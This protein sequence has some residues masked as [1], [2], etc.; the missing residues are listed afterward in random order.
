MKKK[1]EIEKNY[2]FLRDFIFRIKEQFKNSSSSIHKAR[3]EIKILKYND[4]NITAKSFKVPNFFNRLI[5]SFF[6]KSKAKKSYL[7]AV[8]VG[9]FT[10]KPIGYIEFYKNS[11]LNESY[12]LSEYFEYDFTIREPLLNKNFKNKDEIFRAFARF[13]FAL[14]E[15][16]IFHKDFSPGNILVKQKDE[17]YIF[18]IV[19]INRMKFQTLSFNLRAKS[20]SK[21][22]ANDEDLKTVSNEY[23]KIYGVNEE[24]FTKKTLYYSHQL[25]RKMNFKKRLKGERVVD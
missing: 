21:L 9:D 4:L 12:F 2:P 8:K 22:W 20:F 3:N 5:Y 6:R 7:H 25:K 19:D 24:L 18:K 10:P 16:N 13:T 1:Y 17:E 23:A 15:K 14:H 11:L